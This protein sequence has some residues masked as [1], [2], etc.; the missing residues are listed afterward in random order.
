M[1]NY[2]K[3]VQFYYTF[4]QGAQVAKAV[5]N[6]DL[7]KGWTS[8]IEQTSVMSYLITSILPFVIILALFWWLM[9]RMGGAGGMLG[10]GGKK[11]SGKLLEGQTPP[12]SS[13]M[14]PVKTRP[15]P[16]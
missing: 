11:N 10:M 6:G 1:T 3:N 13:P 5:E 7:E 14:W 2:G 16:K 8:N 12:P 4:A 15:W 9:S